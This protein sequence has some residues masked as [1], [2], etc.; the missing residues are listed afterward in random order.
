MK[1]RRLMS[2]SRLGRWHRNGSKG[3]FVRLKPASLLQHEKLADV[4][5][6][7]LADIDAA[8]TMSALPP[9]ADIVGSPS[10]SAL[11]Q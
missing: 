8:T 9:I 10:M 5:Y 6:G 7:S 11:C 4:R 3:H 2:A 1:S